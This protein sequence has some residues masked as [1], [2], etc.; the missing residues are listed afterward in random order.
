[1]FN[2][3]KNTLSIEFVNQGWGETESSL[4]T[5]T[6]FEALNAFFISLLIFLLEMLLL[7]YFSRKVCG[8]PELGPVDIMV[9]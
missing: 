6:L 7:S 4:L 5:T 9:S 2:A 8:A 3:Y 1:M